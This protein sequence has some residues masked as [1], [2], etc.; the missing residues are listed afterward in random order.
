MLMYPILINIKVIL[1]VVM[2]TMLSALMINIVNQCKNIVVELQVK[3]QKF[4]QT[5]KKN[6]SK[7]KELTMT[8]GMKENFKQLLNATYVINLMIKKCDRDRLLSCDR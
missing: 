5:I 6:I 2:V 7:K 8:E 4:S 1:L 3:I